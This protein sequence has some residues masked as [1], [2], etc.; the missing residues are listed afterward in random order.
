M[1]NI[2]S[3]NIKSPKQ[4]GGDGY[5]IDVNRSIGGLVGR[6]R[7]SYNYSPIYYG[8]LLQ[9]GGGNGEN[10]RCSGK[11]ENNLFSLIKQN[12]GFQNGGT[13]I[14]AIQYL[15]N[16]I[17]PLG[18]NA[19]ISLILLIFTYHYFTKNGKPVKNKKGGYDV[20]SILAPLGKSNLIVLAALL[21]LH[22]FAVEL[23]NSK[24]T[25]KGGNN[26]FNDISN[27]LQ[28]IGLDKNG[29]SK[30]LINL[31]QA[32]SFNK[33]KSQNISNNKTNNKTNSQNI[34]NNKKFNNS[35]NLNISLNNVNNNLNFNQQNASSNLNYR[36]KIGGN[37]LKD[38]IAPLGTNAFVASG[39][40]VVLAKVLH[41]DNEISTKTKKG[42]SNIH[43]N[44]L[45]N[46]ITPISFSTFA[47]ESFINQLL[48]NHKKST[49]S[50]K[51][52][53]KGGRGPSGFGALGYPGTGASGRISPRPMHTPA[54]VNKF[55][56]DFDH[57]N[58]NLVPPRASLAV[59]S[60]TSGT[61]VND[62]RV[63]HVLKINNVNS[64][65]LHGGKKKSL[66]KKKK[67]IKKTTKSTPKKKVAKTTIT[68]KKITKTNPKKKVAKTTITKKI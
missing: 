32:F 15:S 26:I 35:K 55:N 20:S 3:K 34:S 44:K 1:T 63:D 31:Q 40:L 12:G 52:T 50:V 29:V 65:F 17:A 8:D 67:V 28:P 2:K 25:L 49:N 21:L 24:K 66:P 59:A 39:L 57:S 60:A 64:E 51:K 53:L 58:G 10:S 5:T 56:G 6:S 27:I 38:I 11:K 7:Y 61:Y 46:I 62:P 9:N 68:Q 4:K 37:P 45:N 14:D 47:N 23:P 43:F 36:N 41:K 13:Q 54:S 16:T 42:G 22:H 18:S 48:V 19:L 33:N 30:I